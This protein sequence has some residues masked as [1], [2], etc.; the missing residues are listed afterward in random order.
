MH[1]L[2]TFVFSAV[3]APSDKYSGRLLIIEARTRKHSKPVF[4]ITKMSTLLQ[5]EVAELVLL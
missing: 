4:S 5:E 1:R 2:Q 3:K